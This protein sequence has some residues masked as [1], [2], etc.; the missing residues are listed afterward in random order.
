MDK[1]S[2]ELKFYMEVLISVVFQYLVNLET[3]N[4]RHIRELSIWLKGR[5]MIDLGLG[6]TDYSVRL[7]FDK[8]RT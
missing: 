6:L 1:T 4:P 5:E 8:K 3:K 2:R 7:V